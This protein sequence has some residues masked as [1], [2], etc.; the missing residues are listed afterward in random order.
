MLSCSGMSDSLQPHGLQLA[1]LLCSWGFS[2]QEYWS[3]LPCPP[4][5]DLPNAGIRP[6][7]S[8]LQVD[9]LP[10]EPPGK[11]WNSYSCLSQDAY[12]CSL[13][14]YFVT[15]IS[16]CIVLPSIV[17]KPLVSG[18]VIIHVS[19]P[20]YST[21]SLNVCCAKNLLKAT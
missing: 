1:R 16:T 12:S 13:H 8:A 5:G 18:S 19:K 21:Q 17:M 7:S 4:L 9:S 3:G 2:R 14:I 10:P 11:L 15:V 6:R 20:G